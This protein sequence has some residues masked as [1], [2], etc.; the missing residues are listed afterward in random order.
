ML[1]TYGLPPSP[2]GKEYQLWFIV[3]NNPPIPSGTFAPDNAG[4]GAM[5]AEVPEQAMD[6]AVFAVTLEPAGG[7]TAPTGAIYLRSSL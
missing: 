2:A 6:S 1:L 4:R 7:V 3:G 5:R